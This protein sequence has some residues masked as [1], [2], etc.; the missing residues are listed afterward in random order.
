MVHDLQRLRERLRL[1]DEEREPL[2]AL[3]AATEAY[4]RV[5]GAVTS[6]N[7]W[8]ES[9]EDVALRGG[10]ESVPEITGE[11]E[12]VGS[13]SKQTNKGQTFIVT[14]TIGIAEELIKKKG[15]PVPTR[16]I[17]SEMRTRGLPLPEKNP[18]NVISARLSPVRHLK[19]RRDMGWWPV[20][21]PWPDKS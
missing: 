6:D 14:Q 17:I 1:M 19:G 16:E 13:T 12:R 10:N 9:D 8:S 15:A 21:K 5:V 20:D 4:E 3:I 2:L 11:S 7:I 18:L